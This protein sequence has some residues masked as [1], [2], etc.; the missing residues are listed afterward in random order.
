V[1]HIDALQLSEL[2]TLLRHHGVS[3]LRSGNL[4][5]DLMPDRYLT[6][7]PSIP[8]VPAEPTA[9]DVIEPSMDDMLRDLGVGRVAPVKTGK[10]S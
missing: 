3:H 8:D 7:R 4:E 2:L 6:G 5:I 10:E 1:E 9:I